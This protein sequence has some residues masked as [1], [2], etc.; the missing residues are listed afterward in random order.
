MTT[1]PDPTLHIQMPRPTLSHRRGSGSSPYPG[2]AFAPLLSSAVEKLSL[3]AWTVA[4]SVAS[5]RAVPT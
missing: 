2:F 3:V 5:Y 1:Q 4:T